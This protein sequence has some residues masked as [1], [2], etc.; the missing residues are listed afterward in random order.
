MKYRSF[1]AACIVAAAAMAALG[2]CNQVVATS[3][4]FVGV[5][6][7]PPSVPANVEVLRKMP[8]KAFV[9]LGEVFIE[10]QSG[11]PPEDKIVATLQKEAAAMG[12]DAVVIVLDRITQSGTMYMGGGDFQTQ[13]GHAVRAVAIKYK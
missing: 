4:R 2:G 11:N 1:V 8:D 9:K 5:P 13:Y 3:D 10:P 7:Y 12:A 6:A